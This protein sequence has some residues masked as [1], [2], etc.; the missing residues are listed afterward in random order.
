MIAA[1]P[2]NWMEVS[3]RYTDI[4]FLRYSAYYAFSRN[5]TF[6]DKSFNLKFRL[7]E[8]TDRYPELSIGFRD[9]IGT[10]WFSSE[11]IVSSKRIG[12]FD[13]TVGVGWGS[14]SS[15]DGITNPFINLSDNFRARS[16]DVGRGGNISFDNWFSGK[17]ISS[18][19]GFEYTNKLSGLRFKFDYDSSNPFIAQGQK[20]ESNYGF[21]LAIPASKLFDINLFKR[22]G[23]DIG[24]SFSYKANYSREIIKKNEKS[25][26]LFFNDEDKEVLRTNDQV[27]SGT[28]NYYLQNFGIFTQNVHINNDEVLLTVN[29]SKYRNLNISNKRIIE[30]IENILIERNIKSISLIYQESNVNINKIS[31]PLEDFLSYLENA[32]T[33]TEL[34]KVTDYSNFKDYGNSKSIF[35]GVIDY[36][37]YSW[38]INPPLKNH[39]GA[40]E[41]FYLG[42]VG[43][44]FDNDVA[45]SKQTSFEATASFNIYDTF[46]EFYLTAYSRLP[47][48]RSD[49]REYLK[50][51]KNSISR[52]SV[53]HILKPFY[54][55]NF[56]VASGIKFGIFEEMYGG[57]GTEFILR[58]ISK[59]WYLKGNFYWVK[60]REFNQRFSFRDYETFTGH[61]TFS[62]E[63]PVEGLNVKIIG[64]RYLAKDSGFTLNLS[65]TFKSGFLL[66]AYAT[67]TDISAIEFGEGSFDKGIYFSIPLDL[68][69]SKYR[70]GY[71]RFSWRNLTRDGGVFLNGGLELQRFIENNSRNTLLRIDY[72]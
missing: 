26:D 1:T 66:G 55:S 47:K 46:D 11:Y 71:A 9:P 51:G 40:P 20:K 30:T 67:K 50:Q 41:G 14:L 6:K 65:K 5:Q 13:F 23:T 56:L 59:P 12:D 3:L 15:E 8:E 31:F 64:G 28:I 44:N 10:G 52:F 17:K 72:E 57:F 68:V 69:S 43:I 45:F 19:Y 42:Q 53:S 18:F 54:S 63:T 35:N 25:I 49:I 39:L 24:F 34:K 2:F 60:Q 22:R 48:V 58:D 38:G 70:K 4:N 62:W 29:Q 32:M 37:I 7:I 36:P 27:F 33:L 16:A 61:L 21:G